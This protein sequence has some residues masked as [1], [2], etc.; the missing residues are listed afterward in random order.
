MQSVGLLGLS[1][2][3]GIKD[4]RDITIRTEMAETVSDG[5]SLPMAAFSGT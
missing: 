4:L 1:G 3:Q 2:S 5:L